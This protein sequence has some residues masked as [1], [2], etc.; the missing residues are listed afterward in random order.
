MLFSSPSSQ[1]AAFLPL[2]TQAFF[3]KNGFSDI[4]LL[5]NNAHVVENF[6]ITGTRGWFF[7]EEN[8]KIY[9]DIAEFIIFKSNEI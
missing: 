3:E 8:G 6:I 9:D 5:Y 4:S 1:Q 7:D 2:F